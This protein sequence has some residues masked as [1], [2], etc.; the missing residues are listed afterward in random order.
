MNQLRFPSTRS[1]HN[2]VHA[3]CT[4][5][6]LKELLIS[7]PPPAP[8]LLTRLLQQVGVI[9]QQPSSHSPHHPAPRLL[10]LR[11]PRGKDP[12]PPLCLTKRDQ[13]LL[14]YLSSQTHLPPP[15]PHYFA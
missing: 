15:P 8:I 4:A 7:S 10:K 13:Q 3:C 12:I 1:R 9:A 14:H 6:M 5:P 2:A 11:S